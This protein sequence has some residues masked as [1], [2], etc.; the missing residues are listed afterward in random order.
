M[1]DVLLSEL[2]VDKPVLHGVYFFVYWF[3]GEVFGWMRDVWSLAEFVPSKG[4]GDRTFKREPSP[5]CCIL[6]VS[7]EIASTRLCCTLWSELFDWSSGLSLTGSWSLG[8]T[9]LSLPKTSS[10]EMP[11][12][13]FS[14]L[15][16]AVASELCLLGQGMWVLIL[17][18]GVGDWIVMGVERV[19][20]VSSNILLKPV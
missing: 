9:F 2:R 15:S 14:E 5:W 3:D 20:S 16:L 17:M 4:L 7:A 10:L 13:W 18:L 8:S 19:E 11:I 12:V 6:L 1:S